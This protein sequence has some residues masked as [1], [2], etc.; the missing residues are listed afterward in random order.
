LLHRA[1]V[2]VLPYAGRGK[3]RHLP[4]LALVFA[5]VLHHEPLYAED[6]EQARARGVNGES[7]QVAGNPAAVEFFGYGGRRPGTT[8]AIEN[9]IALVGRSFNDAFEEGFGVFG[10]RNPSLRSL[11][12]LSHLHPPTYLEAGFLASRLGSASD[13]AFR[14]LQD[15]ESSSS[16][17]N[18]SI[19]GLLEWRAAQNR[20]TTPA[21]SGRKHD[22]QATGALLKKWFP[23]D[24]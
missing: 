17:S 10:S 4:L 2:G 7:S 23:G 20:T 22:G 24:S 6:A 15:S 19:V 12:S 14:H 16:F 9:E 11:A 5:E 21:R 18:L 3:F 1:D 8:E 13:V